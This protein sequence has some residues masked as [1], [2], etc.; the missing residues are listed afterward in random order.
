MNSGFRN[1]PVSHDEKGG[2]SM[3]VKVIIRRNIPK[4]SIAEVYP[5][6]ISLREYAMR[7]K[8]FISGETLRN[9]D[10]PEEIVVIG[11]WQSAEDWKAWEANPK[12][13][14]LQENINILLNKK[15][16][17]GVYSYS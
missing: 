2:M 9:I 1:N 11:T 6:L 13:K 15:I 10:D 17:Y 12:R 8:G 5:L 3:T 16:E 4:D 7:Q 14:E